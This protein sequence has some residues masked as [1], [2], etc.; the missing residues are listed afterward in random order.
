[1]EHFRQKLLFERL[2]QIN[3]YQRQFDRTINAIG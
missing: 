1:M 3:N 2:M